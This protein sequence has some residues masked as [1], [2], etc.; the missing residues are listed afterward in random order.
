MWLEMYRTAES[1]TLLLAIRFN[2]P[3]LTHESLAK[4][5]DAFVAEFE[6]KKP[7]PCG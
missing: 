3:D 2:S 4:V 7:S 6:R 5:L 1:S